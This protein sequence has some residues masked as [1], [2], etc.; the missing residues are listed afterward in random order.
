LGQRHAIELADRP[1]GVDVAKQ[2]DLRRSAAKLGEQMVTA[3][4]P[5][6]PGDPSADRGEARRQLGPAP[7]DGRLV[8]CRRLQAD[9]GFSRFQQPVAV[10]AAEIL[11]VV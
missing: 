8:G 10:T 3:F 2:E 1:D 7:I 11:E 9:E 4:G 5:R 6:Q